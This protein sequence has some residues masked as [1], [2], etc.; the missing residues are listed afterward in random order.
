MN[1]LLDAGT[2]A[3]CVFALNDAMALGALRAARTRGVTVP[4]RISVA[5]FDDIPAALDTVPT[6]STVRL[7]LVEMGVL[8]VR[9][10][11]EPPSD[12][13]RVRHAGAEI[14]LRESTAPPRETA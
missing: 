2:D 1:R 13:L 3:T 7:P 11:L 6:L 5:G 8:A 10:A 9:L 14:V 12:V 4:E